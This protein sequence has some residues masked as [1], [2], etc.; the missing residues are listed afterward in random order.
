MHVPYARNNA[1]ICASFCILHLHHAIV[2]K[3][4]SLTDGLIHGSVTLFS[5]TRSARF[6][7]VK[8]TRCKVPPLQI[9]GLG[10]GMH[11][12]S[13]GYVMFD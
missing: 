7:A 1:K 5:R 12:R 10:D 9:W 11:C 2:K 13:E 8:V 3:T 6:G 4:L